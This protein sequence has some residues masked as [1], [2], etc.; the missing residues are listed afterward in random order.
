[1]CGTANCIRSSLFVWPRIIRAQLKCDMRP[2]KR[3]LILLAVPHMSVTPRAVMLTCSLILHKPSFYFMNVNTHRLTVHYLCIN[4]R[5]FGPEP[6]KPRFDLPCAHPR[7]SVNGGSWG[8]KI[9]YQLSK[10]RFAS[11]YFQRLYGNEPVRIYI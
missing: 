10:G 1:M 4:S 6:S 3:D 2:H 11:V 8:L 5:N 7:T 9:G